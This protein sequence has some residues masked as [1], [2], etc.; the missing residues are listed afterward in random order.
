MRRI[1]TVW[2][3]LGIVLLAVSVLVGGLLNAVPP[4]A[5]TT[6]T[7]P[8]VTEPPMITS[9]TPDQTP[10]STAQD[11]QTGT[12]ETTGPME[13]DTGEVQ[14]TQTPAETYLPEPTEESTVPGRPTGTAHPSDPPQQRFIQ[15]VDP[16]VLLLEAI[17]LVARFFGLLTLALTFVSSV[18]K[19]EYSIPFLT[20]ERQDQLNSTSGRWYYC[21]VFSVFIWVI[22]AGIILLNHFT[23]VLPIISVGF[24]LLLLGYWLGFTPY[25]IRQDL[26]QIL[27]SRVSTTDE[28]FWGIAALI[29]ITGPLIY[30]WVRNRQLEQVDTT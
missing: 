7:T 26:N 10:T 9:S 1:L 19:T 27:G 13:T 22:S 24:L 2:L 3:L 12:P 17:N 4:S 30:V 6:G 23:G 18:A 21:V 11:R 14:D 16:L 5:N 8:T 25:A 29:P 28:I 20:T 15:Q